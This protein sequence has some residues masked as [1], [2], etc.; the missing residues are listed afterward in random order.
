M[1][2]SFYP[3]IGATL[4]GAIALAASADES[5][6][7]DELTL[8]AAQFLEQEIFVHDASPEISVGRIDSRLRLAKCTQ[9]I[10]GFLP[11]GSSRA[12]NITVGI[13]CDGAKPWTIYVNAQVKL[14]RPVLVL[15]NPLSRG[16]VISESDL[17][18]E[19]RDIGRLNGGY[20]GDPRKVVGLQARMPLRAGYVLSAKVLM[21]PKLVRRG[22]TVT[23]LAQSQG[24]EVRSAGRAL[25]DGV[26]GEQISVEN[27]GSNR[28]IQGVVAESGLVRVKM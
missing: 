14:M 20:L 16:Q 25:Q 17:R 28:I 11:P 27:L 6:P 9:P 24:F 4:S 22:Q 10:A 7:L 26:A 18:L 13:R 15:G 12:G 23:L 21:R 19:T 2:K 1:R 5:Q 3:W 8:A